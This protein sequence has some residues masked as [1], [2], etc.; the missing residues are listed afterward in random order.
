M[1]MTMARGADTPTDRW[2]RL[3]DAVAGARR[4][5]RT[6]RPSPDHDPRGAEV[7]REAHTRAVARLLLH[8]HV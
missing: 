6:G 3:R 8:H 5:L 7:R 1:A 4:L 2:P